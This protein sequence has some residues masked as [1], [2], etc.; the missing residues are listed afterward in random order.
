MLYAFPMQFSNTWSGRYVTDNIFQIKS[1]ILSHKFE[2]S[3][4][5]LLL[6]IRFKMYQK[7]QCRLPCLYLLYTTSGKYKQAMSS[8]MTIENVKSD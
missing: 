2:I 3:L 4:L 8:T 5:N 1:T 6:L 7:Q